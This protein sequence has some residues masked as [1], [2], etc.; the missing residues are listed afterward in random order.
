MRK[1]ALS[2]VNLYRAEHNIAKVEIATASELPTKE[3]DA[4]VD[5]VKQRLGDMTL[6]V[7]QTV[8][9]DLIGGFTAK[10]DDIL[11][12]AS[13]KNELKTLRLKLQK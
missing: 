6:E 7:E 2:Y 5:V 3:V 9:P 8:K 12:D 1:I 13:I 10:I 4:I 11:L